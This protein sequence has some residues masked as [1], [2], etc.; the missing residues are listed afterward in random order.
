[1]LKNII[2]E[3]SSILQCQKIP[4]GIFMGLEN[5]FFPNCKQQ[6]THLAQ[7]KTSENEKLRISAENSN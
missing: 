4:E 1:M 7:L 5:Y 3:I 6:K 2:V